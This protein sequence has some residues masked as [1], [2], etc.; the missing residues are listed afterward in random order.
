[1]GCGDLG[2]CEGIEFV[3]ETSSKHSR[4]IMNKDLAEGGIMKIHKL[5]T[6]PSFFLLVDIRTKTFE[7]RKNDREF[8]VGDLLHLEEWDPNTKTYTGR[9]CMR[10]ITYITDSK[11]LDCRDEGVLKDGYVIMGIK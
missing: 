6:W 7:V 2:K 3:S 8:M 11:T 10:E 4:A 1:M 5:K 9:A